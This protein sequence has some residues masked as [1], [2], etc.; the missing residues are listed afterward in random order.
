[1]DG[2]LVNFDKRYKVAAVIGE[3]QQYQKIGYD[4]PPYPQIQHWLTEL[5]SVDEEEAYSISLKV[6]PR[7]TEEAVETL[8]RD[9]EKLRAEIKALQ[10]RNSDLE[11]SNKKLQAAL[12]NATREINRM[13]GMNR[14]GGN[15]G[16]KSPNQVVRSKTNPRGQQTKAGTLRGTVIPQRRSPLPGTPPPIASNSLQNV[17]TNESPRNISRSM[18]L[19]N[20][21]SAPARS[22]GASIGWVRANVAAKPAV[23]YS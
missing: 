4:F 1:M 11:Q 14:R 21:D 22:L 10:L 3:I 23:D 7:N 20:R 16:G 15:R 13:R 17:R 2:N 8:L 18:T 9:E 19:S 6:E 12:N 5:E